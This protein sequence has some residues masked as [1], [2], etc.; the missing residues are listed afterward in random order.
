MVTVGETD[1]VGKVRRLVTTVTGGT[2]A[3][4]GVTS[5]GV[6]LIDTVGDKD[7]ISETLGRFELGI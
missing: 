7:A 1:T 4:P 3:G 5:V 2:V 6:G